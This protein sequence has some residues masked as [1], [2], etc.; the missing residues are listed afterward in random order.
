MCDFAI[1]NF[2]DGMA[3]IRS[4]WAIRDEKG[5]ISSSYYS[6]G[7]NANSVV[8]HLLSREDVKISISKGGWKI[9]PVEHLCDASSY[10]L[11]TQKIDVLGKLSDIESDDNKN[12]EKLRKTRHLRC[13]KT[14]QDF[15]TAVDAAVQEKRM[16]FKNIKNIFQSRIKKENDRQMK[17][18]NLENEDSQRIE[19]EVPKGIDNS[20]IGGT[21][22]TDLLEEDTIEAEAMQKSLI[23]GNPIKANSS[24]E[25]TIETVENGENAIEAGTSGENAMDAGTSGKN[26]TDAETTEETAM[27]ADAN[28]EN[29]MEAVLD[30]MVQESQEFVN[31]NNGTDRKLLMQISRKITSMGVVLKIMSENQSNP[32]EST[33]ILLD[34]PEMKIFPAKSVEELNEINRKLKKSSRLRIKVKNALLSIGKGTSIN[35]T[36]YDLMNKLLTLQCGQLYTFKGRSNKKPSF[37]ILKLT[38]IICDVVV[39]MIPKADRSD[40]KKAIILWLNQCK[41]KEKRLQTALQRRQVNE[42][43]VMESS[44]ED[45]DE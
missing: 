33:N 31:N 34:D 10:E 16:P 9:L 24:G 2:E 40:V 42:R 36:V 19:N 38:S 35:T 41:N 7:K 26:I 4:S 30:P 43:D 5:K 18:S 28:E 27:E 39:Q 29:T 3:I 23:S 44:S 37:E 21:K 8:R 6:M 13:A 22:A 15:E 25:N 45:E 11:A 17:K 20:N 1:V 32:I 12:L 14:F